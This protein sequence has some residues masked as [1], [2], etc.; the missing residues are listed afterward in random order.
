M[1]KPELTNL[2]LLDPEYM[3][4]YVDGCYESF[5]MQL[6]E[7]AQLKARIEEL[8]TLCGEAYQ[9]VGVLSDDCGRFADDEVQHVLDNLSDQKL[10]HKDVLPFPSKE[11][12]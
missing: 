3:K 7:I 6:E 1:K 2:E 5:E 12:A 8:G 11:T 4:A 9:V 10:I